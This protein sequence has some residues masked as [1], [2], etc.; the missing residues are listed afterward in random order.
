MDETP[1]KVTT[2]LLIFAPTFGSK[3]ITEQTACPP[4]VVGAY[5]QYLEAGKSGYA[6]TI[7]NAK[8]DSIKLEMPTDFSNEG[9]Q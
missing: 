5:V 8:R 6:R 1:V 7:E 4:N 2:R 9:E 3:L